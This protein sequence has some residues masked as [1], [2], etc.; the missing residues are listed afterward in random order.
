MTASA[1]LVVSGIEAMGATDSGNEE[2]PAGKTVV[3][4]TGSAGTDQFT[5][6]LPT[7]ATEGQMLILRN[8]NANSILVALGGGGGAPQV[9]AGTGAV[10]VYVGSTTG[11]LRY[12]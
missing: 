6:T 12:L 11:W 1:E 8:D 7:T 10:Y 4:V 2:V 9:A 5:T 3:R